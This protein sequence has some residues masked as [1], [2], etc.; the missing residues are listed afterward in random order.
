MLNGLIE[1]KLLVE[2]AAMEKTMLEGEI[3]ECKKLI[4][5]KELPVSIPS[6]IWPK[7]LT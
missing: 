1:R 3:R 5:K 7:T 4:E 6:R 2:S